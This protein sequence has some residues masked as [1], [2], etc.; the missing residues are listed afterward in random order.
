M[1]TL[2]LPLGDLSATDLARRR[3]QHLGLVSGVDHHG[4]I[5]LSRAFGSL[6]DVYCASEADLARQVGATAAA[7]MRWFLDAPLQP[8]AVPPA[9]AASQVP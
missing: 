1:P 6:A 7:R 5:N 9:P 4:L 8:S 3:L 2:E